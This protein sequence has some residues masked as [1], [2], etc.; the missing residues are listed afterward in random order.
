M[1]RKRCAIRLDHIQIGTGAGLVAGARQTQR[2]GRA[3]RRPLLRGGLHLQIRDGGQAV[4]HLPKR[5]Q[6]RLP[7]GRQGFVMRCLSPLKIG[8]ILATRENRNR[9]AR[10]RIPHEAGGIVQQIE[11]AAQQSPVCQQL[12]TGKSR[13][14]GH[15]NLRRCRRQ[16]PLRLRNV[17]AALQKITRHTNRD[18]RRRRIAPGERWQTE[19]G[20]VLP[21]Q[22]RDGILQLIPLGLERRDFCLRCGQFGFRLGQLQFTA[23][24]R[25]HPRLGDAQTFLAQLH[26][27][28]HHLHLRIQ[29]AHADVVQ[30]HISLHR[31]QHILHGRRHPHELRPRRFRLASQL[32]PQIDFPAELQR[33]I[34]A[35]SFIHEAIQRKR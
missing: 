35:R 10:S 25:L 20:G 5:Y 30:R 26:R 3:L 32:S 29:G 6:N 2:L 33:H 12:H 1:H 14:F 28:F 21:R 18:R 9:H 34:V 16:G 11:L 31:Q 19:H 23:R 13:G 17:W 4:L 15:A 27:L 8:Q 7:V 22:H 24:P